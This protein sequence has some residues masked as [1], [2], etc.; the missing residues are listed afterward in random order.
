MRVMLEIGTDLTEIMKI[1]KYDPQVE[2][3][4]RDIR[5][6]S[7]KIPNSIIKFLMKSRL[8]RRLF[9]T[10]FARCKASGS[11]PDWIVKTDEERIQNKVSMFEIEKERGTKF[12][13]T[14]KLDG[15]LDGNSMITT[16]TGQHRISKIVNRKLPVSVLTYNEQTKQ[17]EFKRIIDYHKIKANRPTYKIGVGFRGKGN[18]NKFICCTDNHKFFTSA[19]WVSA[20][21]LN[22][23]DN[24][25]HYNKNTSIELNEILLGCL[26]GDSSINSNT[27]TGVYRTV[28]F[29]HSM[30]QIEYFLYKKKLFG[31]MF[32]EQADKI[33]GYGSK[34][35]VGILSSN[36]SIQQLINNFCVDENG[37]KRITNKWINQLTPISLAFWYMDDGNLS[38]REDE[39]L[40]CRI[41]MNTQGFNYDEH[42]ILQKGLESKFN[43]KSTI[44]DKDIYKGYC[45]LIDAENT[46]KFC[47]L[48]APYICQSMKYKL[49]KKYENLNCYFE[50]HTFNLNDGIIT[51]KVLSVKPGSEK[52]FGK[53][54]YDL[55]IEDNHNYFANNILLH[56]CSL[57]LFVNKIKKNKYDFGVCSRN[58]RLTHTDNSSWWTIAKQIDAENKLKE[59]LN[60]YNADSVVLQGE[61]I[62]EGI[63]GNKYELNGYD[64]Y[65]FN[66]II[67]DQKWTTNNM[68]E[69][70]E[71]YDIKTVPRLEEG[72]AL[73]GDIPAMVNY[74]KGISTLHNTKR[75]GVVIRNYDRNISCKIINPDFLLAEA[76]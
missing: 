9:R 65:A 24:I 68:E 6:P 50:G 41:I 64:F 69:L 32:I 25:F 30:K 14:E 57:T 71:L 36:I 16:D 61:I 54:L 22:I 23:G 53:Y 48:I 10:F 51:T 42:I 73:K 67:D 20:D 43:I 17:N 2:Q 29:S 31:N 44:G 46:E 4:A 58:L 37:K 34:L 70:L 15:C 56:N 33:S 27:K 12:S 8:F 74:A 63:Q 75:E 76:D 11:F 59:I 60:K 45:L 7:N 3:E 38:N 72:F 39:N 35:K 5:I 26:L 28:N 55:T 62:G 18:R 13:V 47:S 49:P 40:R 21:K 66:L 1:S 52:Q 19:G